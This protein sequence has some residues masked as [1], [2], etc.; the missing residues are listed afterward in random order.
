M[1]GRRVAIAGITT[2]TTESDLK[3]AVSRATARLLGL[4]YEEGYWWGELESNVTITAEHLF[5]THILGVGNQDEWTRIARYIESKQRED[6][7]WAIWYDGP[8]DLSTTIEAYLAMKLAGLSPDEEHMLRA[9]EF[10]LS[11][12]GVERARIFTKIWLAMLG[13]WDWHGVP[14]LPPELILLPKWF[15]VNVYSFACWARGTIVPMAIIQTLKPVFSTPR[16]AHIDELFV[17]GKGGADRSLPHKD[18]PCA[19]LFTLLDR[20]LRIYDRFPWK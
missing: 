16:W 7:T 15:S 17:N 3:Q 4:Q 8:P 2:E 20:A 1:N 9:K 19:R 5:L 12:G 18:T 10:I 11:Q 6:G 14:M 13:E